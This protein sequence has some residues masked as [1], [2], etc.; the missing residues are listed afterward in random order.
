M[1]LWLKNCNS[2]YTTI[3]LKNTLLGLSGGPVFK[4][5]P[6]NPGVLAWSLVG[7]LRSHMAHG[8]TGM[9]TYISWKLSFVIQHQGNNILSLVILSEFS[10]IEPYWEVICS[11]PE[12][13]HCTRHIFISHS[14]K[15]VLS[16]AIVIKLYLYVSQCL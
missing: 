12:F 2:S 8:T 1:D 4:N 9:H 14:T 5:L 13:P 15:E 16:G 11:P 3:L 7:E 6:S 10:H